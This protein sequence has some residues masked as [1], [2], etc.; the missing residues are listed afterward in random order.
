MRALTPSGQP[1]KFGLKDWVILVC[2]NTLIAVFLYIV[3]FGHGFLHTLI[4][5]QAIGISTCSLIRFSLNATR[6][7]NLFIQLTAFLIAM[8]TGVTLGLA[9]AILVTGKYRTVAFHEEFNTYITV[10]LFSSFFAV[11]IT[12]IFLSREKIQIVEAQVQEERMKRLLQEKQ[13]TEA[14]L[15]LLQAQIEPHFLFNTLANVV[16]LIDTA[17]NNARKMLIDF[18]QYLRT[19]LATTREDSISLGQE[20]ETIRAYLDICKMRMG[21]RLHYCLS[22][23]AELDHVSLPPFL[24]QPLVENAVKHG[25]EPRVEGG[26][27]EIKGQVQDGVLRLEVIDTGNG[28]Q[29]H[30][31]TGIGLENVHARLET[32]FGENGCLFLEENQPHGLRAVIEVPY[33]KDQSGN[34]R[35]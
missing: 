25:I 24:L 35:R 30:G 32:L 11:I 20:K 27:V 7:K 6:T 15:R 8:G 23:P 19:S 4:F 33:G 29:K 34:S 17:P 31:G 1:W 13:I 9:T 10:F 2:A 21:R 16:S 14:H 28:L 22:I 3:E 18:N 12:Y 26:K 5:S